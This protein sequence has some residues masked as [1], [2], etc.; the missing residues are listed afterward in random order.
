MFFIFSFPEF[1]FPRSFRRNLHLN[2]RKALILF[3]HSSFYLVILLLPEFFMVVLHDLI[4]S[5]RVH[6]D[7]VGEVQVSILLDFRS[8]INSPYFFRSGVLHFFVL[9]SYS[10]F[11]ACG[12]RSP[13]NF[14]ML[15]ISPQQA[16]YCRCWFFSTTPFNPSF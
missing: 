6:Q 9:L 7:F 13:H 3:F 5:S 15:S 10:I 12:R 11:S 16:Y 4:F 2:H 14:E 8:A 1:K